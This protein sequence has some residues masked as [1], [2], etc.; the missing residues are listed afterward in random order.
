MILVIS[1]V[2]GLDILRSILFSKTL[3]SFPYLNVVVQVSHTRA[4]AR[5]HT[6]VHTHTHTHINQQ[7]KYWLVKLDME[8]K[9]T[10]YDRES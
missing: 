8:V 10:L 2:V 4:R 7:A 1:S 6:H 3:N 5:A 9:T